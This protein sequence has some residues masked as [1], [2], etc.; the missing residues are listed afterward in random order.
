MEQGFN[1]CHPLNN[2]GRDTRENKPYPLNA[3]PSHEHMYKMGVVKGEE[4]LGLALSQ[5]P[6]GAGFIP[7]DLMDAN[8]MEL[9]GTTFSNPSETDYVLYELYDHE[10]DFIAHKHVEGY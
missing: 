4:M 10:G 1:H 3:R 2:M 6:M 5:P 8:R 9:W 7:E